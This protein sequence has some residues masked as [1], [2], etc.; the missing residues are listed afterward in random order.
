MNITSTNQSSLLSKQRVKNEVE[1]GGRKRNRKKRKN[2]K[3]KV[4]D[5]I[6]D[7]MRYIKIK[8]CGSEMY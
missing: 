1:R 5:V 8:I 4:C 7:K 3:E 6:D 2:K